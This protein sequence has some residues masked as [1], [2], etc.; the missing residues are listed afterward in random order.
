MNTNPHRPSHRSRSLPYPRRRLVLRYVCTWYGVRA[1]A[2]YIHPSMRVRSTNTRTHVRAERQGTP[3]FGGNAAGRRWM[4]P[5]G[6]RVALTM[7]IPTS[8]LLREDTA[9]PGRRICKGCEYLPRFHI[10]RHS[11]LDQDHTLLVNTG[12]SQL[13][14]AKLPEFNSTQPLQFNKRNQAP[15]QRNIL[16]P[17]PPYLAVLLRTTYTNKPCPRNDCDDRI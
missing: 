11:I 3:S 5:S 8:M 17:R 9:P 4:G 16:V 10:N 13:I 6:V 2:L 1:L 15:T 12:L 14:L 7:Y